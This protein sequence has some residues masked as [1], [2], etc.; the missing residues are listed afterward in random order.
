MNETFWRNKRVL[1]TGH[2]GFKGG[3]LS[4]WLQ[5][6]GSEVCGYALDPPTT[7]SLFMAADVSRGIRSEIGDI[8]DS[9]RLH[10]IASQC[11]PEIIFHL[12]AQPLV[13][14]SY[15][16][17]VETFAT[18][19]I[20]TVNVLDLARHIPGVRA[21]VII[22]SDKCYENREWVWSYRET[23][24]LGGYDPYSSSKACAEL[25]TN[26]FRNSFFH[27]SKFAEHGVAMATV[28]AGNVIGGGDWAKDRLVP[29]IVRAFNSE[30]AVEIRNPGAVR[31]WQHV[32]D[33][34]AGY[35]ILAEKL[36]GEC[37]KF[38]EA[39]NFGPADTAPRSV[40]WIVERMCAMWGGNASWRPIETPQ[41]HEA[42]TLMLDASKAV[43][44]LD[45]RPRW[46]ASQAIAA[47]M[48]WYKSFYQNR[49]SMRE[50]TLGQIENYTSGKPFS[51]TAATASYA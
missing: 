14:R 24:T 42:R 48:E 38:G 39:W 21:V 35:L 49:A 40:S 25:V 41:P 6:L 13:R 16:E 33:P 20:G 47:T 44:R 15:D 51:L 17:P 18:N 50:F 10:E 23:D 27:P 30:K 5:S 43:S 29:D 46:D 12:A 3:W 8:C 4:L 19:V 31:P 11:R 1:V 26:A 22:T 32:L 28:R 2:T 36:Y 37:A 7:P 45:W 34:L 9:R